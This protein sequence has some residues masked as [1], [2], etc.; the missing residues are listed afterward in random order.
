MKNV[1]KLRI[2]AI[3]LVLAMVLGTVA[4]AAS[5]KTV[6][7]FPGV[8]I[9]VNGTKT[10]PVDVNGNEV[11]A[12]IYNNS[13]YVPLRYFSE[14]MG[15]DVEWDEEN[16]TVKLS[17]VPALYK[18]GTYTATAKG[19]GGD[20]TA[21][22][23]VDEFNVVDV[24]LTGDKETPAF[25]GKALP[26][27]AESAK[28]KG[29]KLDAVAGASVTSTAA[30]LAVAEALAQASNGGSAELSLKDGE[31]TAEARGF[32]LITKVPVTVKVANGKLSAIEIGESKETMGMVACVK[33]LL[34]PRIL[35]H[36]SLAVDAITGATATSN[37][38]KMAVLDCCK[39]AGADEAALYT[40]IPVSTAEET[41]TVDVVVVGMGGSGTAAALSAVQSGASVMAID[42]AGKWAGT[43]A[44]TSGPAAVNAPSQVAAEYEK[45]TDPITKEVRVK[46]AGE[47]LVDRDALYKEWTEYT[48]VDGVQHAKT[49]I[50]ALELD[51]SGET[52]DWL[53]EN[54]FQFDAAKGFVGGKWGIFTSYSGNKSLTESFFAKAYEAYAEKG[55]KYMLETEATELLTKDGKVVGVKA[56][57]ADGTKVTINAKS[58]ILATGGFGGSD[59]MM[60][61]Y[62]GEA[63]R[64]YGMAQNTGD[65]MRM[66]IDVGAATYNAN[67]PPMS[68]FVAPY[69]I[70]TA[71]TPADNDIPYGLVATGESLAVDQTGE[72]KM[73][74]SALAMNAYTMGAKYYTIWSKEQIDILRTQGLSAAAS[75][76][77][78]SQG[79]V[80]ADT[81]LTNIDA[82]IEE[83]V[84]MGF[85]YKADSLDALAEA[86]GGK[87]D[88][89]TLKA[90]VKGYQEAAEGTDP[91]GKKADLFDRVGAPSSDSAYYVAITGAPY[92]YSTCGALDV[93]V[94]MRVLDK[95]GTP[96][97][98]LYA[99]GTDSMGVLFTNT[100]GYA[101]YG[102]IAQ[103][104]AFVSGRTAGAEAAKA[105]GK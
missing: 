68:H 34:I 35:E 20:V 81:P 94:S 47:N 98:G 5:G 64:L 13:T 32:D 66:A 96:I 79:G 86:I 54:G 87:M 30:K 88:A 17:G 59:E 12:F 24:T 102:G 8:S 93:D 80:K 73:A 104:Y 37:A 1:K 38:V 43:S 36:Q 21:T 41:Y 31:Y 40:A 53:I 72:R 56:V 65:G 55:G 84:K 62:M 42:K 33:E 61:E 19:F 11:E 95:T 52:L 99:V 85:I 97:E 74:E 101:N 9:T 44:I 76:R 71:F 22:V 75:G 26:K 15:V 25:G 105:A 103:G 67:M 14:L 16:N 48:T 10:T 60:E 50:I 23:T 90:S 77:Y 7:I 3:M 2:A 92:I 100:K 4:M 46:K 28:A 57:K 27:L 63:W 6:T 91:L 82:V 49:E 58:V 18:P 83:G 51:K 70:M 29:A 78:L 89:A 45:W 69:Q 39:Q